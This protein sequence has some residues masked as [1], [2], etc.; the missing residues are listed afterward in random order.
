MSEHDE[1][2]L[3]EGLA[4]AVPEP[5]T[6]PDRARAAE[7]L[8]RRRRRTTA[9]AVAV[10][11]TVAVIGGISAVVAGS[12]PS[13][14]AEMSEQP[15]QTTGHCPPVAKTPRS[16]NFFDEPDPTLPAEVPDGAQ[17]VRI[18]A[19]N[20]NLLDV[21]ND[22]LI[23][24]VDRLT[25]A[26]NDIPEP[27]EDYGCTHELGYG[28]RLVFGYPDQPDFVVSGALYGCGFV[29]IGSDQRLGA[30]DLLRTF[31]DLLREGRALRRGGYFVPRPADVPCADTRTP[32]V[33]RPQD[34]ETAVLCV[35]D[36]GDVHRAVVP[37]EDLDTLLADLA[38]NTGQHG[39]PKCADPERLA[40]VGMTG[41]GEVVPLRSVCAT[42]QLEI[43]EPWDT[44]TYPRSWVPSDPARRI[45]DALR[46]EASRH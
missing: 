39:W 33:A 20:G 29:T 36:D 30:D 16:D 13:E 6:N 40:L 32:A 22:A 5:P 42:F 44:S 24:G 45:L 3:R 25:E 9:T 11:A 28:Y 46:E 37:D 15:T 43:P 1:Q 7:R 31:A 19:G 27:E 12:S 8:A 2:W 21:P 35:W 18:C 14:N 4:S 17:W 26:V 10:V 23:G 41:W 38:D 34:I